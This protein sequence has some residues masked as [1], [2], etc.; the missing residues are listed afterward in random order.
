MKPDAVIYYCR[1]LKDT[2]KPII[3]HMDGKEP[4]NTDF[5]EMRNVN[6]KMRFNNAHAVAK[7]SGATTVLE[8]FKND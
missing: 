5:I 7:A 6:I 8:V 3:V 2:G 1:G 4:T